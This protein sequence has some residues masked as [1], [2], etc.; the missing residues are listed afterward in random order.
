M[1][2]YNMLMGPALR[3]VAPR[4]PREAPELNGSSQV[5]EAA[6]LAAADPAALVPWARRPKGEVEYYIKYY[7]I[8]YYIILYYNYNYNYIILYYNILYYNLL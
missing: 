6:Q 2:I 4:V 7:I 5:S 3:G 1:I 8:L